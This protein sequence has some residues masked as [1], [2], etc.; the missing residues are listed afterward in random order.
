MGPRRGRRPHAGLAG[1][2]L[3]VLLFG[4][5][6]PSPFDADP[7]ASDGAGD[8]GGEGAP[9]D[10]PDAGPDDGVRDDD[11]PGASQ[12][13]ATPDP[14]DS[15][16]RGTPADPE[17]R[18]CNEAVVVAAGETIDGQIDALGAADFESALGFASRRFQAEVAPEIFE[19]IITAQYPILLDEPEAEFGRCA[20]VADL[21]RMEVTVTAGDGTRDALVYLLVREE[22]RWSIDGATSIE[23]PQR[24]LV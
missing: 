4:C 17:A 2:L 15:A 5:T 6:A 9:G 11:P 18:V 20:Q 19:A 7:S 12:P 22:G 23:E 13:D 3:L 1:G 24:E 8:Q 21:A 14:D 10:E 16:E